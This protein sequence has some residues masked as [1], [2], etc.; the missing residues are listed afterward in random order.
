[1]EEIGKSPLQVCRLKTEATLCRRKF[2]GI[3]F[4]HEKVSSRPWKT[5]NESEKRIC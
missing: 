5:D 2:G 3:D 4:L 1:M